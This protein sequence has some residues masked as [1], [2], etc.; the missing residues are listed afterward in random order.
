MQTVPGFSIGGVGRG[1]YHFV[2]PKGTK[3]F[4]VRLLGVH[5]GAYGGAV[6]SPANKVIGIHQGTNQGPALIPGTPRVSVPRPDEHPERGVLTIRPA[7]PDTGQVWSL[8]L[9]AAIDL[10]CELEG[11]PPYLSL[12]AEEWFD[13]GESGG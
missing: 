4:R 12:R 10:G 11:V 3:R 8:V 5:P 7:A 1:R 13:P 6:L 2:V 9:W